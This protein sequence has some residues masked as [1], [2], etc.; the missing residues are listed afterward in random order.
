MP[1]ITSRAHAEFPK[2]EKNYGSVVSSVHL[3][4]VREAGNI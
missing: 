1:T 4:S 2:N 3:S